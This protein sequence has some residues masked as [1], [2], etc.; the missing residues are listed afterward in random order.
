MA[1]SG[2]GSSVDK[3]GRWGKLPENGEAGEMTAP[4]IDNPILNSPFKEPAR[5]FELDED[6]TPTSV[7]LEGRRRSEYI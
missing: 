3:Q 6:G 7:E 4:K 2:C 1:A 5:Y